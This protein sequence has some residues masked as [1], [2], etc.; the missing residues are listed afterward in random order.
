LKDLEKEIKRL[1]DIIR[2][3]ENCLVC[4]AIADPIEVI[5]NTMEI[6]KTK[7]N[8]PMHS[9]AEKTRR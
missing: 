5:Q 4:A 9:D 8:K 3:A 1:E 2:A 6:L 7:N